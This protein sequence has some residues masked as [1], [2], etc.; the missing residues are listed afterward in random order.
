MTVHYVKF[1]HPKKCSHN[2]DNNKSVFVF[3]GRKCL[4]YSQA[5]GSEF[6]L[7]NT[8]EVCVSRINMPI[9]A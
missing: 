9:K 6:G 2:L 3:H 4:R 1:L 7:V 8:G 5:N